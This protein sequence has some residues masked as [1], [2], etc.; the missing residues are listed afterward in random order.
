MLL[1]SLPWVLTDLWPVFLLAAV[2]VHELGHLLAAWSVG[3]RVLFF[4]IGPFKITRQAAG[5][6]IGLMPARQA[7]AGMVGCVPGD[8]RNLSR[9]MAAF[10]AAGPAANLLLT[11][12]S[13]AFFF[14]L[15][16]RHG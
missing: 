9:R 13:L 1:R 4:A 3:F 7:L 2:V 5:I 15:G 10:I 11:I 8:A 16:C 12:I 6:R 14:G